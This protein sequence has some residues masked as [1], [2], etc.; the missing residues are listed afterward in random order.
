MRHIA[1]HK[2][3]KSRKSSSDHSLGTLSS[4]MGTKESPY[5]G[6]YIQQLN[7]PAKAKNYYFNGGET[8]MLG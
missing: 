2:L 5:Q 4:H 8:R 1:N 3:I 6:Y 7:P